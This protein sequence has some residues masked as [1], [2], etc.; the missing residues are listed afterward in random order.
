MKR[1]KRTKDFELSV[2]IKADGFIDP[3]REAQR[4]AVVNRALK[5]FAYDLNALHQ[6]TKS[7]VPGKMVYHFGEDREHKALADHEIMEEWLVPVM[8][9]MAE[10]VA[11]D[12]GDI[13]EIGFGLG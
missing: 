2:V 3:P 4:N 5:E 9:A 13:L 6:Q 8:Q 11:K 7:F 10:E 12:G 1:I